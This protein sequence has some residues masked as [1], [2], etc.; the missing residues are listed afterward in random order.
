M[1]KNP[2][3]CPVL[4]FVKYLMCHPEI[5]NGEHKMFDGSST[6]EWMNTVLKDVVHAKEHYKEFAKLSLI[7]QSLWGQTQSARVQ[8]NME[9][10]GW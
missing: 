2:V 1:S 5:L 9:H 4:A 8:S 3:I 7:S 6:Y 10:G